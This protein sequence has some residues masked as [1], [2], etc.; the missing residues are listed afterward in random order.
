MF[1]NT[2]ELWEHHFHL[3]LCT[4]VCGK[5][6]WRNPKRSSFYLTSQRNDTVLGSVFLPTGWR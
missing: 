1:H 5:L 2:Q 4:P 3:G 6:I